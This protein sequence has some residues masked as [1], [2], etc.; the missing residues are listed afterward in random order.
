MKRIHTYLVGGLISLV[1]LVSIAGPLRDLIAERVK[2][3]RET[4]QNEASAGSTTTVEMRF[5]GRN[6]TF[7]IHLPKGYNPS[8]NTPLVLAFHGGGGS[9]EFMGKDSNYHL[10]SKS[11]SAGFIL[12]LP[13]GVGTIGDKL[14]TWNAGR[15]CGK[16]R[17]ENVNDV[18]FAKAVVEYMKQHYSVDARR[19]YAIGMSNGG[20]MSHRLACEASDVFTAIASVAG[21][22]NTT[23]CNPSRPIPILHIHAK[24]DDHVLYNGGAGEGAFRDESKVTDF[25]SVPQTIN[26]WASRNRCSSAPA[27]RTLTVAG[28]YCEDRT[29][30]AGDATVRLCA[31][32]TGGHSWPGGGQTRSDKAG[33]SQAIS[34]NDEIWRFFGQV[35][36]K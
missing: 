30:C 36:M 22:D 26:N 10:I 5:D 31:T 20:M 32:D 8:K 3:R 27:K 2:E 21:T 12:A 16:A 28:A 7:T 1:S 11:D 25:T 17:D 34:A 15:C 18:G 24:D 6:R 35:P 14:A 33:P 9:M 19:V 13:N 23:S 4:R 29:G